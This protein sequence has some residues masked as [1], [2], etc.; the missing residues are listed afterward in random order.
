MKRRRGF[1]QLA[2]LH[3]LREESMHGYQ[4][5]K[6]LKYRSG[7]LYAASAGTIYPALQE[8]LEQ[9]LIDL[10]PA[11]DKKTYVLQ[12]K[13]TER[14]EDFANKRE[15]DFWIEWKARWVWQNSD[16]AVQLKAALEQWE[17]EVRKAIKQTRHHPE[18][19]AKLIS[20]FEEITE[21]LQTENR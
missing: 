12:V 2:I 17:S 7:G 1:V 15:G 16:E 5:M 3:L 18:K 19:S 21:R 11:S 9:E 6:E 4:I 10:E 8:L 14:L 13:G 20:F